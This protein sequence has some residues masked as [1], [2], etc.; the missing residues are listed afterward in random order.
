[1]N[2]IYTNYNEFNLEQILMESIRE[3][4]FIVSKRLRDI[5]VNINSEISDEILNSHQDLNFKT[6]QTFIDIAEGKDDSI[7]FILANK[8]ADILDV[9]EYQLD[10]SFNQ[11]ILLQTTDNDEVY[12]KY[13]GDMKLGRFINTIFPNK[14]PASQRVEGGQKSKDVENFVRLYKSLFNQD[15]KFLMFDIVKGDDISYWYKYTQYMNR[16]GTLGGSCMSDVPDEYL[17]IYSSNENV[18]MVILYKNEIK[19]KIRGRAILWNLNSPNGRI[20]M[21]RIYT[22]DSSDEQLF[23]DYASSMG[24]LYKSTQSYGP[25]GRITDGL[26]NDSSNLTLKC[27]LNLGEL[28]QYPYLDTLIYYNPDNGIISNKPFGQ[29]YIL[30]STSGDYDE[31][32]SDEYESV[33]SNYHNDDIMRSDA[34]WCQIGEDWVYSSEALRVYNTGLEGVIYAVPGN[35]TVVR[36]KITDVVDHYIPKEK[37]IW[38]DYLNTWI[39]YSSVREVYTDKNK[40]TKVLDHKKRLDKNFVQIGDEYFSKNLVVKRDEKWVLI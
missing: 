1:M 33:Y 31:L 15:K 11:K 38:S 37:A 3:M 2:K 4:K 8:A 17:K 9:E 28:D 21:D 7:S 34:I 16:Q 10:V 25:N 26:T 36:T 5:L 39:F 35:P 23:M 6:K 32:D 27:Q 20:F 13:R 12:N 30:Q 40:T 22:N 29:K 24:W 14:F 19:D 18:S